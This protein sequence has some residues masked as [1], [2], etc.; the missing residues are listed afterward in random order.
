[1][2]FK[3]PYK[4]L[5]VEKDA[6]KSEI[7]Q[8]YRKKS[9]K[10]HPDV[11]GN[12]EEFILLSKAYALL[13]DDT[14]R[15]RY[16]KEGLFEEKIDDVSIRAQGIFRAI[17]DD[18]ISKYL[19][20]NV[21]ESD[22]LNLAKKSVKLGLQ[23]KKSEL[24]NTKAQLEKINKL[25][26]LF[27]YD[28]DKDDIINSMIDERVRGCKLLIESLENEIKAANIVLDLYRKYEYKGEVVSFS[29]QV[30]NFNSG[31]YFKFG[32]STTTSSI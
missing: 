6:T 9:K 4:V 19:N 30:L 10:L 11:G 31:T 18:I 20:G 3:N 1:M 5:G 16:D 27:V 28:S 23:K 8:S 29:K 24:F 26:D 25:N 32:T 17:V 22:F 12:N 13:V 21:H 2:E 7:K 14:R 15:Q